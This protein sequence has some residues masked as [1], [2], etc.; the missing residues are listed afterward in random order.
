MLG[1]R[2]IHVDASVRADYIADFGEAGN[3][4]R[5]VKRSEADSRAHAG[6]YTASVSVTAATRTYLTQR[7]RGVI[8]RSAEI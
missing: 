8:G 7:L 4:P 3:Q 2:L 6:H 1:L 5:A